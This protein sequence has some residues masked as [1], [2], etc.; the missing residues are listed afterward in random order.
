MYLHIYFKGNICKILLAHLENMF[1][2][3]TLRHQ[4]KLSLTNPF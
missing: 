2:Q 3:A 1:S 4:S